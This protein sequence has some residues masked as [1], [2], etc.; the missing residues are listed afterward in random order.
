MNINPQD[1]ALLITFGSASL[2]ILAFFFL[3]VSAFQN[4]TPEEF[5]QVPLVEETPKEP[6]QA[7]TQ[8]EEKA[9]E[10]TQTSHQA[11]NSARIQRDASRFFDQEDEV[12]EAL[13]SESQQAEEQQE[14]SEEENENYLT[15]YKGRIAALHRKME[16]PPSTGDENDASKAKISSSS[17]RRTTI[18]YYLEERN[19]IK[20]P[21]PVY[22]CS[23]T[24]KV[25][26]NI[27]VSNLGN[28]L[29]TSFNRTSSTT[30]NGCLIDQALKYA[31]NAL[32]NSTSGK[33]QLGTITFEF[34]G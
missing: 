20:I 27:E 22:T 19:S 23:A 21:N 8:Q 10:K 18:S 16:E 31:G 30:T 4:K 2:L 9:A 34:Q 32:F 29:K 7:Q 12:R 24:G 17:N 15:D 5:Y 6:E 3:G 14:N 11:I 13:K 28:V 1:K 26:I 33:N 25:V